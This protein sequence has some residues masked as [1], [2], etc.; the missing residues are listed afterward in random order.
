MYKLI[1][2]QAAHSDKI[3]S[4]PKQSLLNTCA[5]KPVRS[6]EPI[7]SFRV[8]HVNEQSALDRKLENHIVQLANYKMMK[9]II[10]QAHESVTLMELDSCIAQFKKSIVMSSEKEMYLQDLLSTRQSMGDYVAYS[11]QEDTSAYVRH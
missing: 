2:T 6:G 10:K 11:Y 1:P 8:E 9:A 7:H 4:L 3:E 5:K